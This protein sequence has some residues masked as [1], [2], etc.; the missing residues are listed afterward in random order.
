MIDSDTGHCALLQHLHSH[1]GSDSREDQQSQQGPASTAAQLLARQPMSSSI[2]TTCADGS[3]LRNPWVHVSVRV[4]SQPHPPHVFP[5]PPT[6][7]LSNPA[8]LREQHSA[9]L[10]RHQALTQQLKAAADKG[11]AALKLLD[12]AVLDRV[13]AAE[14][15]QGCT[16][17]TSRI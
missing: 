1:T 8:H 16:A 10:Q 5:N 11:A 9:L 12:S 3:V 14:L 4:S 13:K 6:S 17:G 15:P 7:R 2:L